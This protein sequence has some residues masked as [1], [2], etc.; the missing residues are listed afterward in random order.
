MKAESALIRGTVLADGS[1][2]LSSPVN[3]PPGPVEVLV[4]PVEVAKPGEGVLEVLAR[5]DAAREAWTGYVPQSAEEI[6][7]SLREVRDEWEVRYARVEALENESCPTPEFP[8]PTDPK[9]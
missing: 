9:P 1:L 5:I 3:L 8:L 4:R 6:D 2:H 7:A